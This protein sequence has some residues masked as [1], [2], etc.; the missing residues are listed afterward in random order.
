[1]KN[2][3]KKHRVIIFYDS[4]LISTLYLY[5]KM[6]NEVY[7]IKTGYN[8]KFIKQLKPDYTFEFRVERFLR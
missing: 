6:F 5:L 2:I 4:F 7:L 1:M 8:P 3:D